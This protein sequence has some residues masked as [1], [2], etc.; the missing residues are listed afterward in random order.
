MELSIQQNRSHN[1]TL[2]SSASK[3]FI[4]VQCKIAIANC[5]KET[6]VSSTQTGNLVAQ[7]CGVGK[8]YLWDSKKI[9]ITTI[10]GKQNFTLDNNI[11]FDTSWRPEIIVPKSHKLPTSKVIGYSVYLNG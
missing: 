2:W 8:F 10:P 11:K 9:L 3:Y 5:L 1:L 4:K 7:R 6:D